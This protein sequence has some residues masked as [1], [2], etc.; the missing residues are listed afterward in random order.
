VSRDVVIAFISGMRDR[1]GL[2]LAL[3]SMAGDP[4]R[5]WSGPESFEMAHVVGAGPQLP[6][7]RSAIPLL[8]DASM[9][10]LMI[11]GVHASPRCV[12]ARAVGG[13]GLCEVACPQQPMCCENTAGRVVAV[14]L[15]PFRSFLLFLVSRPAE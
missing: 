2:S 3:S 7:H 1:A 6:H 13:V 11:D 8:R 14:T 4:V 5:F 9:T 10:A 15:P 12:D